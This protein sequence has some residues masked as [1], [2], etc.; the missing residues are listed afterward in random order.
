MKDKLVSFL[1]IIV[2][3]LMVATGIHFFLLPSNLSIGGATGMALVLSRYI[4][5]STGALL[6]IVNIVLFVL[7][8]LVIGNKFGI[9]TV[10]A[11][12]GLSAT[13]WLLEIF[14]PMHKPIVSDTFLQLVIAVLLY[15][16]GAGM[17]LNQYAS[18]GGSD[19]FAMILQKY[20]GLDLG[21]GCLLT[22]FIVTLFAG[23]AYGTEIAL[24]SL[25]GVIINGLVIDATIDGMNT[26]KYCIIN[27]DK[28]DEVCR[29]LV[30]LG[31]SANVYKATGAFS[32]SE[33]TVVQAVMTR[34]DFVKLKNFLSK[35][36]EKAFMVVSNAHS[37]FGW[38]WKR[39]GE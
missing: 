24:F 12:L 36:D 3:V 30:G 7:G 14:V 28:P 23:F 37:V 11:S 10:C 2:G 5:L 31:R 13:V 16:L 17:V 32:K 6:V 18:T 25:V 20:T 8:F 39:I 26:A 15:G 38:H 4:P 21:K 34:S 29:F 27:T 19:I 35:N 22:D 33:K 9:K 1:Y